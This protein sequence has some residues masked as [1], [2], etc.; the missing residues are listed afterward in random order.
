MLKWIKRLAAGVVALIIVAL[1]GAFSYEQI[2]R[3]LADRNYPP[4]GRFIDV[5]GHELH[6]VDRG[7]GTPTVIFETGLGFDGHLP[8]HLVQDEVAQFTRSVSYDRA[9]VLYSERGDNPKSAAAVS[10][11]LAALLQAGGFEPPYILVAHS[12]AGLLIRPF[13]YEHREQ[14]A[15]IVLVD[16]SHPD[17]R[18]RL[19]EEMRSDSGP[20]PALMLAFLRNFGIHRYLLSRAEPP[21]SRVDPLW[22]EVAPTMIHRSAG[23]FDEGNNIPAIADEVRPLNDF[24]DIP[25]VVITGASPTRNQNMSVSDEL[26]Q[27]LT[28]LWNSLQRDLLNLST[29]SRHVLAMESEHFVQIQQ[30][31]LVVEAIR[32]LVMDARGR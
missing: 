7:V 29:N 18:N 6:A 4:P 21:L 30:P 3:V 8:W 15:G 16:V 27:E 9:G 20:P 19:P 25:L 2:S 11:E 24:G 17:Q 28:D 32:E 22:A 31:E 10:G 14:I 1:L 5:G 26:K 12:L 23:T 13:V